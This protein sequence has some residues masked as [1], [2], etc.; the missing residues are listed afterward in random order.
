MNIHF[1][2]CYFHRSKE[3]KEKTEQMYLDIDIAAAME[4]KQSGVSNPAY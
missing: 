4:K 3:E 2:F 1:V